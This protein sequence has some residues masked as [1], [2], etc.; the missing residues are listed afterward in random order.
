[1]REAFTAF[2][3]AG[4]EEVPDAYHAGFGELTCQ[5]AEP[6][7]DAAG[8]GAGTRVLDVATGPGYV[9][10]A[11]VLRGAEVTGVDFAPAMVERARGRVPGA[12][13]QV[14]DA[15][16]LPFGDGSFDAVVMNFGLLHLGRPERALAEAARVLRPGGG[17]A[18]TV[19]AP[20]EEAVGFGIVLK[21]VERHGDLQVPLP[22]GPPFFRFSDADACLAAL[23]DAGLVE[24]RVARVPQRWRLECPEALFD[25]MLHGTV[26]TAAL[27]R[28]QRPEA[29]ERIQ[30]AVTTGA[31]AS[32]RGGRIELPMPAVLASARKSS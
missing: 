21:A 29:L 32:A 11:A 19:W 2:E 10:E 14:G 25:V 3:R 20:P 9:A 1:V 8:V 16:G 23:R 24:G 13:F 6:L 18:F 7:L 15:E 4:W 5:C 26:R 31:A 28:G 12:A 30:D 17:F 27:L 22:E